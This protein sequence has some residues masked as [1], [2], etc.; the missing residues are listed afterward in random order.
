M[1]EAAHLVLDAFWLDSNTVFPVNSGWNLTGC[2]G[3]EAY[4]DT[5]T[6][7]NIPL[8]EGVIWLDTSSLQTVLISIEEKYSVIAS[9]DAEG[10]HT[11]D[12]FF[13]GEGIN[14]LHYLAP[15]YGYWIKMIEPGELKY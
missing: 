7:P 13:D 15:G 4:Y 11:F 9:F 12:P 2:W 3:K 6:E 1:Y 5:A 14:D 10:G 8:P